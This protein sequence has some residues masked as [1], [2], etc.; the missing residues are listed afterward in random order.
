MATL[1]NKFYKKILTPSKKISSFNLQYGSENNPEDFEQITSTAI[2]EEQL[3]VKNSNQSSNEL[4]LEIHNKFDTASDRLLSE[5]QEIINQG[6]REIK[7]NDDLLILEKLGFTNVK[8]VKENQLKAKLL[9]KE[10][11]RIVE[12]E[13]LA[14][15][16]CYFKKQYPKYKCIT[17]DE[18]KILCK[19]YSLVFGDSRHYLGEIPEKNVKELI[20]FDKNE[21]KDSDIFISR[22]GSSTDFKICAPEKDMLKQETRLKNSFELEVL[23]PV[24]LFP[25]RDYYYLIV[26]KWGIEENDQMLVIAEQN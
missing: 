15:D 6:I 20:S 13:K 7:V 17:Y 12:K 11:D 4:V 26:S 16:I 21:I 14:R 25:L 5:A 10:N 22:F 23:D 24:V 2:N 8:K 1:F 19:K 9:K 18:V 3:I